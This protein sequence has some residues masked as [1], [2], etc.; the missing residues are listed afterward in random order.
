MTRKEKSFF[1][2]RIWKRVYRNNTCGCP[3]CKDI[4][5]NWLIIDDE[6]H[7][8]Y[9]FTVQSDYMPEYDLDYRDVL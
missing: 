5:K 7:A 4:A 6:F 3:D 9:L 2:E 8:D 1:L